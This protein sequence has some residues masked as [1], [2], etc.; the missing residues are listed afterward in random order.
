ME[1][2]T[3]PS[4]SINLSKTSENLEE[5][6]IA[7]N[8]VL[9]SNPE[10]TAARQELYETMQELLNK[11]A[12]LAYQGETNDFYK[13]RTGAEFQFIHP[14]DRATAEPFPPTK[15]PPAHTAVFWLGWSLVGLIPAGLG[16]LVIA[17]LAIIA[18]I[19]LLLQ[20]ASLQDHRRAGIVLACAILLW[21]V[22]LIFCSI[23]ILHLV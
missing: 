16:T 22:A 4:A 20:Q 21:L 2:P 15:S 11:D 14:K 10:N 3:T 6:V 23:L 19:K 12:F 18:A 5:S 7:L 8:Q 9:E 1:I 17:P 13:I